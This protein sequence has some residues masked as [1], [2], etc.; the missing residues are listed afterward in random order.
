VS[1]DETEMM[2]GVET[3]ILFVKTLIVTE[4]I[5]VISDRPSQ[6]FTEPSLGITKFLPRILL[7]K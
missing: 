7:I 4:L 1:E 6:M 3:T 2:T 5:A